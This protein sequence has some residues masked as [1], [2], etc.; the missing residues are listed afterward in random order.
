MA[1]SRSA[2]HHSVSD[3]LLIRAHKIWR[4]PDERDALWH[5]RGESAST[6]SL[7]S[8]TPTPGH[9]PQADSTAPFRMTSAHGTSGANGSRSRRDPGLDRPPQPKCRADNAAKELPSEHPAICDDGPRDTRITISCGITLIS[10]RAHRRC[11]LPSMSWCSAVSGS[12]CAAST[13][14]RRRAGILMRAVRDGIA[15]RLGKCSLV[16]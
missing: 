12:S 6:R 16:G 11:A 15:G 5:A 4:H 13:G 1:L 14:C 7:A 9:P 3:G 10:R 2:K 8:G